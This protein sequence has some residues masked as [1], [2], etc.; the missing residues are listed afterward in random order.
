MMTLMLFMYLILYYKYHLGQK[1]KY[2]AK[3]SRHLE[4]KRRDNLCFLTAVAKVKCKAEHRGRIMTMIEEE[5]YYLKSVIVNLPPQSFR[6]HRPCN[7]HAHDGY[8]SHAHEGDGI[9]RLAVGKSVKVRNF[10]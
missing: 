9:R 7:C 4:N 3:Y 1:N 6:Q 2:A 8:G 5:N 10:K